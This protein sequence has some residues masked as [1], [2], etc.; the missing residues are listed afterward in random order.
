LFLV[1]RDGFSGG[2]GCSACLGRLRPILP[3]INT[4]NADYSPAS[5]LCSSVFIGGHNSSRLLNLESHD[6]RRQPS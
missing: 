5:Y 1:E 3:P 6:S 2:A 4:E